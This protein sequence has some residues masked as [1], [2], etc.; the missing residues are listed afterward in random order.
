MVTGRLPDS[1]D[2]NREMRGESVAKIA[3]L[4]PGKPRTLVV[5][6]GVRKIGAVLTVPPEG[7]RDGDEITLVLRPNASVTGRVVDEAGKPAAGYVQVRHVPTVKQFHGQIGIA[8]V[9]VDADGRFHCD[10]LPPGGSYSIWLINREGSM[11]RVRMKSDG[12]QPF[13]LAEKLNVEPGQ[14]VDFGTY[15]VATG[16]C[17]EPPAPKAVTNDVPITGRIVN[18]EGQPVAG[19]SV[20]V[21][22]FRVPKEDNLTNWLKAVE[23]GAPPWVAANLIDWNRKAPEKAGREATTDNNGRF[24]LEGFGGE[25]S[26]ELSL[27]HEGITYKRIE[28]VT[29]KMNPIPAR[30]F[31]NQYGPGAGTIYGADFVYAAAPSRPIQGVVKDAKTGQLLAGVEIRSTRFAESDFVGT[32]S[33]RTTTDSQGRFRLDGLP[34][35]KGNQ[36]LVV[37][38]DA[39]PYFLHEVRVPDPPGGGAVSIEVTL[40][41]G[42]WIEGKLT[43]GATGK[44][45]PAARISYLPFLENKFAQAIPEFGEDRNTHGT[46]F[47]DRYLSK[48]DGSFRLVGLPGRAIV[49]AVVVDREYMTGAGSESIRG[50]TKGGHFE[51]YGNPVPAGKHWPT[52]MKEIDP[53]AAADVIH[54]DLQAVAGDSVRLTVVDA[55]GKPVRGVRTLGMTGR[56]SYER[57]AL[58]DSE[59]KV[60]NLMPAE[61]RTVMLRHEDRKLG[62]VVRVRKGD[63]KNGPVA[64][65]LEPLATMTGRVVDADGSSFAGATVRPDLLPSGDFSPHLPDVATDQAGRFHVPDVP[66]GCDYALAVDSMEEI[67]KRRFAFL[68]KATVKPG[69]TTDVGEIRFKKD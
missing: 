62:K 15:N 58:A 44:P 59:G 16:K 23:K 1:I 18:L 46:E 52:V 33:I 30:G 57:E 5:Q 32:M 17:I 27:Q 22:E 53:P 54:V 13:A 51:T 28:V 50:M 39:Q 47:Q 67:K 45:I 43:D 11:A 61:E 7:S 56:G 21:E 65:T 2:L 49:G 24:R 64:V 10:D 36:L 48:A 63:D 34:K 19:V 3:G 38:N 55:K 9:K 6:E 35:G 40:H 14:I 60:T 4:E 20:N 68:E 31:R 8:D 37:P 41:R 25:R 29:R 69:E 12:F 26:L 42:I 66:I